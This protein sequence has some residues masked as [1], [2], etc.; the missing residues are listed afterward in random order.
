MGQVCAPPLHTQQVTLAATSLR[1]ASPPTACFMYHFT[2]TVHVTTHHARCR[3]LR[4]SP[5]P[6]YLPLTWPPVALQGP[7]PSFS[8]CDACS[9]LVMPSG[10]S[11]E[12]TEPQAQEYIH[13]IN[14]YE[15]SAHIYD[16]M[17][18]RAVSHHSVLWGTSL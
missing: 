15:C 4:L 12:D 2:T 17:A 16:F 3:L 9:L 13:D 11:V 6:P 1:C 10:R 18:R 5:A 7:A 14:T 8:A